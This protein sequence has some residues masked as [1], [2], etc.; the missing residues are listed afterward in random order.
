MAGV[1]GAVVG[2]LLLFAASA[3]HVVKHFRGD[4][5]FSFLIKALP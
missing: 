2:L 5:F 1:A 3:A 4:F